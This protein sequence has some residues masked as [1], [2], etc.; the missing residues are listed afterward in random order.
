[1]KVHIEVT[2]TFGH[3]PNYSWVRRATLEVPDAP[4]EAVMSNDV[5]QQVY[6]RLAE[7]ARAH[8]TTLIF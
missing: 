3:E 5:W 7:L 2:D 1:M 8:R 4:L 6:D